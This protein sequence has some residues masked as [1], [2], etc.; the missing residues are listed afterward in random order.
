VYLKNRAPIF[1]RVLT[2]QSSGNK[3]FVMMTNNKILPTSGP[4]GLGNLFS[5]GDRIGDGDK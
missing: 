2:K 4:I 5:C 3:R 1:F